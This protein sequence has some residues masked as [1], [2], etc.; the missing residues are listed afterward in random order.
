MT[1]V[2]WLA[3]IAL[4]LLLLPLVVMVAVYNRLAVLA[5][6]CEQAFADVDVQLRHRHD[7]IPSLVETVRSFAGHEAAI[8]DSVMKAR[9][10]A[11]RAVGSADKLEAET[12]LTSS[13]N[14]LLAVVEANP[15]IQAGSHFAELRGELVDVN[16]KISAARRFFNLA[17]GEYNGVL[18]Q[19]PGNL[20]GRRFGLREKRAYSLGLDRVFV[21]EAPAVKL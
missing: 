11:L 10:D 21:E 8:L 13:I 20:I 9:T 18:D 17:V 14:K 5:R 4:A 16:N 7:L 1:A 6:R 12:M 19:F 3:V 15:T 2:V